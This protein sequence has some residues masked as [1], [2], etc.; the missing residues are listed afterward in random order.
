MGLREILVATHGSEAPITQAVLWELK[1]EPSQA[2]ELLLLVSGLSNTKVGGLAGRVKAAVPLAPTATVYPACQLAQVMRASEVS[3]AQ[4]TPRLLQ[5]VVLAL[6][7]T[8]RTVLEVVAG[9][10]LLAVSAHLEVF[11][12]AAV[13]VVLEPSVVTALR[14]SLS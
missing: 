8:L 5:P 12:E 10:L 3:E 7:G 13:G 4:I 1:A 9:S 14:A 2:V 6:C 11:T